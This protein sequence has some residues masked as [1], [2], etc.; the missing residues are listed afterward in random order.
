MQ[1]SMPL[2]ICWQASSAAW[3]A[4]PHSWVQVGV[5]VPGSPV[6]GS[7]G[8]GGGVSGGQAALHWMYALRA[9]LMQSSTPLLIWRQASTAA[10]A[11]IPHCWVQVGGAVGVPSTAYAG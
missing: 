9:L 8:G 10:S 5:P 4:W 2:A 1:S 11:V 3:A 7:L 6:P